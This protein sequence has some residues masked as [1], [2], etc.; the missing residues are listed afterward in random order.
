MTEVNTMREDLKERLFRFLLPIQTERYVDH[1]AFED[2]ISRADD[3]ARLLKSYELVPKALLNDLHATSKVL[4]AEA[5]HIKSETGAMLKMAE[6]LE[7]VFD[8]ILLGE[9]LEDRIPG[10]PRII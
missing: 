7:Y 9:S 2:V 4:R 3:A 6:R 1:R 10:V 8:L 5:L